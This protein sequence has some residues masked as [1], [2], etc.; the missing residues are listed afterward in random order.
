MIKVDQ[1]SFGGLDSPIDEQGNC[2]QACIASIFDLPLTD[3]FDVRQYDQEIGRSY[4]EAR[5]FDQ[6]NQWLGR[7]G[8]ACIYIESRKEHPIACSLM[9][10]T[11]MMEVKSTTLG[12]DLTHVVVIHDGQVVHDPNPRAKSIGDC[13]GFYL[14]VPRRIKA[15]A[16]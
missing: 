6:F 16:A 12:N 10:G 7:F 4:N 13:V 3:A 11:H 14:F 9:F 1:T 5:W 2:W 8:L 15:E